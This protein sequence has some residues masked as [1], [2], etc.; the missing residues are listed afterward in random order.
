M[1]EVATTAARKRRLPAIKVDQA[2]CKR[3]GGRGKVRTVHPASLRERRKAAGLG[4]REFAKKIGV[5]PAYLSDVELGRRG[6]TARMVEAYEGLGEV[7]A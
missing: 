7:K 1:A 2:T 3:C 4:L 5:T 6:V